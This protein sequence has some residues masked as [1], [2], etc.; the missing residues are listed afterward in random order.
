MD[1]LEVNVSDGVL[2]RAVEFASF[3]SMVEKDRASYFQN[4]TPLGGSG[5]G[6][7]LRVGKPGQYDKH[8]T[9]EQ[10]NYINK[11]L[12]PEISEWL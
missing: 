3:E 9:L 4:T 8:L 6:K 7:K 1:F 2:M 5:L 11:H 12:S 10:A